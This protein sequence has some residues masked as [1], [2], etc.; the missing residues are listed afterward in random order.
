MVYYS[1]NLHSVLNERVA[2]DDQGF[3]SMIVPS[4]CKSQL[5]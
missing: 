5:N 3:K 1:T 4:T 2:E